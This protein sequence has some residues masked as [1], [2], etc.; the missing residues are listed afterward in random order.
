MPRKPKPPPSP[1]KLKQQSLIG[2]FSSSPPSSPVLASKQS[3]TRTFSGSTYDTPYNNRKRRR[4]PQPSIHSSSED[5]SG[6]AD[7][8]VGA[9]RFESRSAPASDEDEAPGPSKPTTRIIKK[10]RIIDKYSSSSEPIILE[11]D[12]DDIYMGPKGKVKGKQRQVNDSEEDGSKLQ[13]QTRRRKLIKGQRPLAPDSDD[14]LLDEVDETKIIQSRFRKRNKK[15]AFQK[16]LERLKRKKQ[17]QPMSESSDSNSDDDESHDSIKPFPGAKPG[18]D[19]DHNFSSDEGAEEK[20]DD[21]IVEDEGGTTAT[22]LPAEFSMSTHQDLAHHFKIICQLFVHMAVRPRFERRAYMEQILKVEEYFSVP[23][24]M[25]RRKLS[26]LRDSLVTSSVWRPGFKKP[27]ETHPEFELTR[28]EFTIPRCD[29][30]HLGGRVSTLLGRVSGKPYNKFDF[31]PTELD[32]SSSDSSIDDEESNEEEEDKQMFHLGRFCAARTRVF[33][34][35]NHWEYRLYKLL[36]QEID[37]VRAQREGSRAFV[38][39]AFAGGKQ[40]PKNLKDADAVMDWLDQ[41]GVVEMG[42]QMMRKMMESA[43][44]LDSAAKKGGIDLDDYD[45][46]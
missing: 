6:D 27:L 46:D 7:S 34:E 4:V 18:L 23:L 20:E 39:V 37:E 41:R 29:A 13:P 3:Q 15:S 22:A 1:R 45:F 11:E 10:R 19:S 14:D 26:G 28:L 43:Q 33:H 12:S 24:Q 30:C 31:E 44:K 2:F 8:D 40:P 42:W 9:I 21:F 25:T 5:G 17:G 32:S 36:L 16:N 38:K 35:F